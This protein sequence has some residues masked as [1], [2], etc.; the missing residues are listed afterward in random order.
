MIWKKYT[1]H[2]TSDAEDL[3]SAA[4]YDLGIT[5]V[6]IEDKR[7]A[8]K[9]E[10]MGLFGDVVPEM[11]KD[12]HLAQISFYLEDTENKGNVSGR[13]SCDE[14]ADSHEAILARVREALDEMRPYAD[15]G[16]GRITV[17]ETEEEDWINNWKQYFHQFRIDDMLIVPSWEEPDF[18]CE[19]VERILRIDPGTAFGT[20]KHETTQLAIRALRKYMKTGDKVLDIGTGSGILGIIALMDGAAEVVGTDID[21][22]V[23]PAIADNLAR[24][25]LTDDHFGHVIGNV[26]DDPS[27]Q[28]AVRLAAPDGYDIC[29][30]NII[31][32]IL[33]DITPVAARYLKKGGYFLTSGILSGHEQL[34]YDAM[35]AAGLTVIET[36]KMG[37]WFMIAAR[38]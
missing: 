21:P 22:Q 35:A 4:L 9:E 25:Q 36:Q 26:I 32:E 13:A 18:G 17:S 24:N 37:D 38:Y 29:V 20:G 5:S 1:I 27:T 33:S 14:G 30:S 8:S 31:A 19:D 6:E 28:E 10:L 15:I 34:V 3:V 23:T 12:D 16:E 11:P 2:T 7:P